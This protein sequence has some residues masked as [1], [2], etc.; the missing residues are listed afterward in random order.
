M[1][2]IVSFSYTRLQHRVKPIGIYAIPLAI[3]SSLSFMFSIADQLFYGILTGY[4]KIKDILKE[5]IHGNNRII[6]TVVILTLA[7][8]FLR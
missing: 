1:S 3:V 8:T 5:G 6:R 4:V 7:K 2:N